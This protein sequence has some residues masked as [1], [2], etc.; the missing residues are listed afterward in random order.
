M[1]ILSASTV[2]AGAAIAD[3]LADAASTSRLGQLW[4][5]QQIL[6]T[7][8]LGALLVAAFLF[9]CQRS[10]LAWLYGQICL[11][12]A[13]SA[14]I[15]D[16]LTEADSWSSWLHYRNA[17]V[18]VFFAALEMMC[19]LG[20]QERGLT[21]SPLYTTYL[22]LI[23]FLALALLQRHVYRRWYLSESPWHDWLRSLGAG[24]R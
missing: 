16:W 9:Y 17:F 5:H 2:A 13:R 21:L 14:P 4:H 19:A 24:Q 22:P 6:L 20:L 3:R 10:H 18:A 15:A 1:G 8:S 7:S 23:G 12:E 11:A